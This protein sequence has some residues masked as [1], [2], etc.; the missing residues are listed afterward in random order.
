MIKNRFNKKKK[1]S[2][3]KCCDHKCLCIILF[4]GCSYKQFYERNEDVDPR[5][6]KEKYR[7]LYSIL[8]VIGSFLIWP[9]FTLLKLPL[10]FARKAFKK[11]SKLSKPCAY[12]LATIMFLF[13]L[14]VDPMWFAISV[15]LTLIWLCLTVVEGFK[16]CC[17][18]GDKKPEAIDAEPVDG[19][20]PDSGP[21]D[22]E[23]LGAYPGQQPMDD[24]TR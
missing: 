18:C 19:G 5:D 6:C 2:G 1:Y 4:P 7:C 14:L 16:W 8:I 20:L 23:N 15:L 10:K 9:F 13:V 21:A 12:V 22:L 3:S 17:G 24:S 11:M